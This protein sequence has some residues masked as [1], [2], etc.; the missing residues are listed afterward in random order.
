MSD[1]FWANLPATLGTIAV[2]MGPSVLGQYL[3]HK[4]LVKIEKDAKASKDLT[5]KGNEAIEVVHKVVNSRA[6]AIE[7]ASQK[8][9]KIA[10]E[11]SQKREG[12]AVELATIRSE[13]DAAI[14][15]F[16]LA[17]KERDSATSL[18][19]EYEH[20]IAELTEKIRSLGGHSDL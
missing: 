2:L 12:I 5:I 7:E 18:R 14:H 17:K 1:A 16:D 13:R 3:N 9:A 6:A 19:L 10:V 8:A 4:K 20:K 11:A 15:A